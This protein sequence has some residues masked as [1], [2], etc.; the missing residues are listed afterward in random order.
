MPPDRQR[1]YPRGEGA[2]LIDLAFSPGAMPSFLEAILENVRARFAPPPPPPSMPLRFSAEWY[3]AQSA[4]REAATEPRSFSVRE[5]ATA[6]PPPDN[7]FAVR[8]YATSGPLLEVLPS[9]NTYKD[10]FVRPP[11]LT[12]D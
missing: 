4:A 10:A 3:S 11:G 5:Y 1:P 8:E 12:F 7:S 9:A 2:Q 6:P